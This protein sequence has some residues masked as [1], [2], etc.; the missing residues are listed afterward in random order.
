MLVQV[1]GVVVG[2]LV[3]LALIWTAGVLWKGSLHL[4]KLIRRRK[5][6]E[7]EHAWACDLCEQIENLTQDSDGVTAV[8]EV[9]PLLHEKVTLRTTEGFYAVKAAFV[10]ALDC[11]CNAERSWMIYPQQGAFDV[12]SW[13]RV[14]VK[15][16]EQVRLAMIASHGGDGGLHHEFSRN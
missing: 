1:A 3:G 4:A 5:M 13:V 12:T 9:M 14:N 10:A 2:L 11:G 7:A 6:A 8:V 16:M 15:V